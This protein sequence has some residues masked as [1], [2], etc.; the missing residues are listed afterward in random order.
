MGR[1]AIA[2]ALD[3]L[4]CLQAFGHMLATCVAGKATKCMPCL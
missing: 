3:L 2:L 4:A 1:G